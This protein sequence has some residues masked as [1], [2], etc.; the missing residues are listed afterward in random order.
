ML[1]ENKK[2]HSTRKRLNPREMDR[3]SNELY[4]KFKLDIVADNFKQGDLL[5]GEKDIA[6]R[7]Q[8]PLSVAR[9]LYK[10]LKDEGIA[11]PVRYKGVFLVKSPDEDSSFRDS[12]QFLKLAIVAFLEPEHPHA[13]YNRVS[14]I[15]R[16]FDFQSGEY[17]CRTKLFNTNPFFSV[18]LE[19]LEALKEYQPDGILYLAGS[20]TTHNVPS[21]VRKLKMLDIPMVSV[22]DHSSDLCNY[23]SFDQEQI[24]SIAVESLI[25]HGH[26]E[27][28]F[29]QADG[30]DLWR[31]ERL[32]G[33]RK[34][35]AKNGIQFKDSLFYNLGVIDASREKFR[36]PV[37]KIFSDLKKNCTAVL[38]SGDIIAA[39]VIEAASD[40]GFN[41]PDDLSVT[42]ID[43][44][45]NTRYLDITTV[46]ISSYELGRASFELLAEVIKTRPEKPVNKKVACSLLMRSTVAQNYSIIPENRVIA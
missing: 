24:A 23:V 15:L 2:S 8:V 31:Q 33:Y 17:N 37:R 36:E 6:S 5:P 40:A 26:R 19:L 44:D 12:K 11:E 29:I 22:G 25:K 35:L 41:V 9:G 28:A 34:T 1:L 30:D 43:D 42:G 32:N 39:E 3:L 14:G 27:I 18:E 21:D 20:P 16:W 7:Y 45:F 10:K 38:C 4:I 46:P 13:K